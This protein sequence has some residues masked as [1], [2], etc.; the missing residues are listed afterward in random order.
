MPDMPNIH[1]T[2]R[3]FFEW[4]SS[5]RL[6]LCLLILTFA[7]VLLLLFPKRRGDVG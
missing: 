5:E 2:L 6:A 7:S 4:D 3:D 1:L